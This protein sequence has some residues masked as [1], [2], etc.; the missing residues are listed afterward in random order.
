MERGLNIVKTAFIFMLVFLSLSLISASNQNCFVSDKSACTSSGGN[1]VV[2]LSDASN[3]HG[4]TSTSSS[5]NLALCCNFAGNL[6]C[7]GSNKILGL[8]SATNAHA[9]IPNQTSYTTNVCYKDL[10]CISTSNSCGDSQ[11]P[12]YPIKTLSLFSTSNSHL[13]ISGFHE[14]NVCCKSATVNVPEVNCGNGVVDTGETCDGIKLNGL[15]CNSFG[16]SGGQ[17]SCSSRC[18]IITTQCTGISPS[19]GYVGD[20][21]INEGETCDGT[22]FNGL[23]CSSFGFESGGSLICV[24]GQVDTSQCTPSTYGF[25]SNNGTTQISEKDAV[26]GTTRIK[27]ILDYVNLPGGSQISLNIYENDLFLDDFI[28]TLTA[29]VDANGRATAEWEVTLS[30]LEKTQNDYE[31][32]YFTYESEISNYLK[33]NIFEISQCSNIVLCSSYLDE[34]SC[35]NDI[36]NVVESSNPSSVSCD[37][38]NVGCACSWSSSSGKCNFDY[39]LFDNQT[40][41]LLGS[42]TFSE[43]TSD[44]CSDG[45]LSYSWTTTWTGNQENKP[46]SCQDG[47][48]VLECPA[49]IQLPLFG[50]YNF[51]MATGIVLLVYL[52]LS[53]KQKKKKEKKARH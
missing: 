48:Q 50:I 9:Q 26:P 12:N 6:T 3:A 34:S 47:S 10:E 29:T 37:D 18:D 2:G 53:F 38:P 42:C 5:Y 49:Q 44:D 17:I 7:S 24:G 22:N 15:T 46:L 35:G 32:F 36:C 1:V 27:M 33:L 21:E 13:G 39:S 28:K 45:F 14:I 51:I 25:W 23:T 52:F 16:F 4:E 20:G 31:E 43:Q 40:Q 19:P 11:N 30:D 41:E 8:S